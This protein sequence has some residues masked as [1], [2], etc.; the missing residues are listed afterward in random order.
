MVAGL[1]NVRDHAFSDVRL[2]LYYLT[3]LDSLGKLSARL[4]TRTR[5]ATSTLRASVIEQSYQWFGLL[6]G[7]SERFDGTQDLQPPA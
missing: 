3:S 7:W 1:P 4:S 2:I 5:S 6:S